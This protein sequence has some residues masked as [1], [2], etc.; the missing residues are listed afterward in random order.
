MIEE[1]YNQ[2]PGVVQHISNFIWHP[3]EHTWDY[4]FTQEWPIGSERHQFSYTA[5]ISRVETSEAHTGLGDGLLNYRF[6]AF[7]R[8]ALAFA[9]RAS[10]VLPTGRSTDGLGSD[11]LGYQVSLPLSVEPIDGFVTHWNLGATYLPN[12]HDVEGD[13]A[14]NLSLNYG[15]SIVHLTSPTFNV[16]VELVGSSDQVTVGER[17]TDRE[18]SLFVSPGVRYAINFSSGLQIVPGIA[19]PIGIGPSAGE[20]RVLGYLSFEHP[21]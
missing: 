16:L 13:T 12:A 7:R 5:L 21:F 9:P 15:M 17:L 4:A 8:G 14:S 6:E 11:S 19:F 3:R 2:E 20:Y 1:A 18:H 10:I